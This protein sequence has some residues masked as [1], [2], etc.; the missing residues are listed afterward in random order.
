MLQHAIK[1]K[2]DALV[3]TILS[4]ERPIDKQQLN[5]K[6]ERQT[7]LRM[8]CHE[9]SPT[10]KEMLVLTNYNICEWGELENREPFS[11]YKNNAAEFMQQNVGKLTESI[12]VSYK[13]ESM[14]LKTK[15]VVNFCAVRRLMLRALPSYG[16]HLFK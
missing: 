9:L 14:K 4:L 11:N 6:I 5:E 13:N 16:V 7:Y 15:L 2:N 3:S 12:H 8:S 10:L 1:S